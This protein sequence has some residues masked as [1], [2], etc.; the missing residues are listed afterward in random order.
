MQTILEVMTPDPRT[1][2]PQESVQRA[3]QM[4]DELNVG[5]FPCATASA[6]SA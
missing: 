2:S 1:I 4:M 3:A 5:A 6:W